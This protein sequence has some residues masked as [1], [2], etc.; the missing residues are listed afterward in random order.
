MTR[1]V[2]VHGFT[3][4]ARSWDPLLEGLSGA[5]HEPVAVDAP[6]HGAAADLHLD[7]VE[8]GAWLAATGGRATYVG[9][10]MGGRLC[11]HAA[12]ADP[13]AVEGLVLISATG[14]LDDPAA[15]AERRAADGALADRIEAIGV[16]AFL[17]EWLAQPL[18]AGL[19]AAAQGRTERL[20]NTAAGLASSLRLAG[21]GT[22]AP[23]WDRLRDLRV[24]TLV[25]AGALDAKFAGLAE[26]LA[27][28]IPGA[29]LAVV[30]GAG[31][32]VHLEQPARFLDAL[33]PWLDH[34]D[35][36]RPAASN[37]P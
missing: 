32:T 26:R 3:Q 15:R 9:Y 34:A 30:E 11:L 7:L 13:V 5:G 10:S 14:G 37:P 20:H 4:T 2:L 35:S 24:R 25:V 28:T 18:F 21:T 16:P 31:H 23:L 33:L 29:D 36:P 19:D 1:L 6:G 8:G 17:D 12:L 22:Q 27:S